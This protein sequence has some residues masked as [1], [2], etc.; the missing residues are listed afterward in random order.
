[1]CFVDLSKA[2]DTVDR[3]LLWK[4]L[5]Q[6]GCPRKF[7]EQLQD[8]ME[9][10]LKVGSLKSEPFSVSRGV[11]QGCTLAPILFNVYVSCI[12]KLLVEKLGPNVG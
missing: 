10:R 11:K 12:T 9:A 5:Y 1:M 6:V 3:H 7:I 8:G 2:F 4:I